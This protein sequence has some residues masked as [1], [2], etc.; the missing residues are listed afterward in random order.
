MAEDHCN[1]AQLCYFTRFHFQASLIQ[2]I[3]ER[4]LERQQEQYEANDFALSS[5][6]HFFFDWLVRVGNFHAFEH[7]IED[8]LALS[9][10]VRNQVFLGRA[11][12]LSA[13]VDLIAVELEEAVHYIGVGWELGACLL[14]PKICIG[15]VCLP[16]VLLLLL[17]PLF[18]R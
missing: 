8:L 17:F 5:L 2:I 10:R 7:E 4:W 1:R 12:R 3:V 11:I 18:R 14:F 6:Q 16:R 13:L 15:G 9:I